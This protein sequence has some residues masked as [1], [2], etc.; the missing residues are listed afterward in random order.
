MFWS[1]IIVCIAISAWYEYNKKKKQAVKSS[2]D[3][4][5]TAFVKNYNL[6]VH[7]FCNTFLNAKI[8][9]LSSTRSFEMKQALQ[10]NIEDLHITYVDLYTNEV[11]TKCDPYEN[12][13]KHMKVLLKN[14]KLNLSNIL[15]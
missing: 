13:L 4:A 8:D 1:F 15:K 12:R 9:I 5:Q 6:L 11:F 3:Y 14:F 7:D 2:V 10:Q